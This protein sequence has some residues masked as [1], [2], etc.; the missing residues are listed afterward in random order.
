MGTE[1]PLIGYDA[2]VDTVG[3]GN[4]DNWTF[5]PFIG[6]ENDLE[7][8]GRGSSDQLGGIVSSVYGAKIMKDLDL[9]ESYQE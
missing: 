6:Y 9:I 7:I 4:L 2:H 8:G 5:D 1:G 3:V